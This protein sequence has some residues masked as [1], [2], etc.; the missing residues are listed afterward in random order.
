MK[1]KISTSSWGI[2]RKLPYA[3]TDQG[4]Y[5]LAGVLRGTQAVEQHKLII[6]TFK[7]LSEYFKNKFA[8]SKI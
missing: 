5:M 1:S 7:G 4:I 6:R 3:F 8:N 2:T